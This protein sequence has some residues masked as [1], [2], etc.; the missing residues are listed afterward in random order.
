M[1]SIQTFLALSVVTTWPFDK[2][3]YVK[4]FIA[5]IISE[6]KERLYQQAISWAKA[7]NYQQK[8]AENRMYHVLVGTRDSALLHEDNIESK[9]MSE[10][11]SYVLS[12]R[13]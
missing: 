11:E 9:I 12:G 10:W 4:I 2:L 13:H 1:W 7:H 5:A 3:I 8:E 6:K